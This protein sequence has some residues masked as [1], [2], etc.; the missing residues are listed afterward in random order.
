MIHNDITSIVPNRVE[1]RIHIQDVG[2]LLK[3]TIV[4]HALGFERQH[5]LCQCSVVLNGM[6]LFGQLLPS[7]LL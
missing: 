3:G 2:G 4:E 5:I 7:R 1:L 6:L